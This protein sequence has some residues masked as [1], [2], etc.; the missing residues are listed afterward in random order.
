MHYPA[1]T[2]W[3]LEGIVKEDEIRDIYEKRNNLVNQ[4][5]EESVSGIQD[6]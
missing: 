2:T 1:Q 5:S 4:L 6:S 3:S